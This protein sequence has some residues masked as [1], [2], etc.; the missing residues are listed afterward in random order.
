MVCEGS[1]V[2]R[3]WCVKG[4]VGGGS[5]CVERVLQSSVRLH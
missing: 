3:E 1:V 2:W 5:R 4:V